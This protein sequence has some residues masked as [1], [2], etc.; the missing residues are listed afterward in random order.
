MSVEQHNTHTQHNKKR[1]A[2]FFFGII[3]SAAEDDE[4]MAD[5]IQNSHY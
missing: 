4:R 1:P 3:I 2:H 5:F